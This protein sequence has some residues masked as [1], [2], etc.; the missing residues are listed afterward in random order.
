M[1][2]RIRLKRFDPG[3]D[4]EDYYY[5]TQNTDS[6]MTYRIHPSAIGSK[7]L[8]VT[9]PEVSVTAPRKYEYR[10]AYHPEDVPAFFNILTG[11]VL[12][13][14]SPTQTGR[15]IYDSFNSN[16]TTEQKLNSWLLGNNGVV[17]DKFAEEHPY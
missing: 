4:K 6:G 1:R 17:S 8:E 7:N 16:L 9:L 13:R 5:E 14:L 10:S 2:R 11:N 12:G 15:A 3:K